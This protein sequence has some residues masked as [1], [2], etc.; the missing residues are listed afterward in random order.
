MADNETLIDLFERIQ[1]FLQRLRAY[2][3]IPLTN[4]F[5]ELLGKIMA[6]LLHI[7]ALSTKVMTKSRTSKLSLNICTFLAES[8]SE[9][10]LKKL[11]GGT[12]VDDALDRLDTLTK[13]ENLM[14]A[15]KNLEIACRIE[16]KVLVIE[17]VTLSI[18]QAVK[19]LKERTQWF[20]TAFVHILILSHIV[21][22]IRSR[23]ASMFVSLKAPSLAVNADRDSQGT[24]WKRSSKHGS[25]LQILPSIRITRAKFIMTELQI[26][27]FEVG[28]TKHGRRMVLYCGFVATVRFFGLFP[29]DGH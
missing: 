18:E 6:Q 12:D 24:S 7:L 15:A 4:G 13:E 29:P 9:K 5:T 10:F 3:G 17:S 1:C 28:H 23:S 21:S 14:A 8:G 16:G 2:I 20:L 19:A 26:G 11:L 22:Q 27:L 25:L